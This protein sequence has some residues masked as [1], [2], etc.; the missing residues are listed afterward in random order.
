M[1]LDVDRAVAVSSRFAEL[2]VWPLAYTAN[3]SV[4]NVAMT[5]DRVAV[6]EEVAAARS[7]AKAV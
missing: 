7:S 4:I 2:P 6:T 5:L 3:V 1:G